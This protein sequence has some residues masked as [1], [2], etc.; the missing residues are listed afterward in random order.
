MELNRVLVWDTDAAQVLKEEVGVHRI[1]QR[2]YKVDT[3]QEEVV[4]E[5]RHECPHDEW[6]EQVHVQRV[7][8]AV[9][10]PARW[11]WLTIACR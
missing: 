9:Q 6:A 7:A 8:R 10:F 11:N 1:F 4:F 5:Q 2:L 3:V